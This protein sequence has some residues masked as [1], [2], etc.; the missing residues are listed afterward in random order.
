MASIILP[1]AFQYC[2]TNGVPL[3]GGTIDFYVPNTTTRKATY[4]DYGM[5]VANPNPVVLNSAGRAVIIGSGAY[6]AV[7]KDVN[8]NLIGDAQTDALLDDGLVSGYVLPWLS[9][10]NLTDLLAGTGLGPYIASQLAAVSLLAGPTGPTGPASTVA[11]PTGPTG[12][13]GADGSN[14][15][16]G[17]SGSVQCG[18]ASTD[19]NGNL[20]IVFGTPF[21]S[22]SS[23][24]PISN[25]I[26]P[27]PSDVP[28]GGYTITAA[29][30]TGFVAACID[31]NGIILQNTHL[32]WVGV[33]RSSSA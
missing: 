33:A 23:I 17:S 12:P 16:N 29:S 20:T 15:S 28:I 4:Q 5:T 13:A 25:L 19:I 31:A 24:G 21:G 1:V 14:G 6:R 9:S 32:S 2:D 27:G 26:F 30:T 3:S 8:G 10:S 18:N 7:T 22:L 11:G